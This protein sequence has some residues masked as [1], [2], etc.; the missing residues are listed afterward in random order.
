MNYTGYLMVGVVVVVLALAPMMCSDAQRAEANFYVATDGNDAWSGSLPAPNAAGTDGPFATLTQ[1]RD[2]IREL[3]ATVGLHQPIKVLVRGGTYYLPETLTLGPEDSGTA[4]FPITYMAY[5]DE[6]VV[7]GGGRVITGWKPYRGQIWQ[8]DLNALGLGELSF[9]QLFYNG[10][11]QPLARVPNVDPQH[12][13]T[14]GWLYV[15]ELVMERSK[16][17]LK[18]D[19]NRLD[20][21]KWAHPLLAEVDI[22]PGVTLANNIAAIGEIDLTNHIITLAGGGAGY[23][24]LIGNRFYI[25][26]V[27]EELDAAGEWYLDRESGI[28]Y[29]WPPDDNLAPGEVVVP[30]LGSIIQI[31]GDAAN[32]AYVRYLRLGGFALQVCQ[33]DAVSLHAA[34]H[35]TIAKCTITNTGEGGVGV[36]SFCSDNRVVGN[37]IAYTGASGV[38][39]T[40]RDARA[41]TVPESLNLPWKGF[42]DRKEYV[43]TTRNLVSNNH[44]HHFGVIWRG[45]EGGLSLH[46]RANVAS[47]NLI[48]DGPR[49][50]I[51]FGTGDDYLIEYND[52]HHVNLETADS[53]GIY[54]W[55]IHTQKGNIIRFN[56]VYDSIGYGMLSP[57]KWASPAFTWGIYLDA[58]ASGFT[59]Y[60]N[61]IVRN[62]LGGIMVQSGKQ[63]IIA[64][65]ILVEGSNLQI[66]YGGF[67]VAGMANNRFARNIVSYTNP[68]AGLVHFAKWLPPFWPEENIKQAVAESDY[69]L[70]FHPGHD[71]IVGMPQSVVAHCIVDWHQNVRLGDTSDIPPAESFAKWQELGYEAHSII[72]DPL[73]VDPA[74]D[75]YR[76]R[77]ESPAFKLGFKPIPV[78][79]IGLYP[80]PNRASWPVDDQRDIW[81]EEPVLT[82][83]TKPQRPR[84]EFKARK[85]TAGIIVDGEVGEWPWNEAPRVMVLQQ[86]PSGLPTGAPKSYG[87]AAYD[88]EA[89]Y[90]AIRNLVGDP[91]ALKTEGKWG[92]K[93]GVEIAF[94]D[95]SGDEPG[96][97]LNLYG[98]PDGQ[99]ESVTT[100]GAP[101]EV[102]RRLGQAVTYAAQVGS[103]DWTCEWRIPWAATGIDPSQAKKLWFNIGVYKTAADAWVNWEGT[104]GAI[105]MVE[106]AGDLI[107]RP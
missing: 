82:A 102:A 19:P 92:E 32:D 26:N 78:E 9:K 96:P 101:Q 30:T 74:N 70:F 51:T 18:Y 53:G 7:L 10:E 63:D 69:N 88:D 5:P 46:G 85:D 66:W 38:V 39:V 52:M 29:F 50:A 94:Q 97:I 45:F 16:R 61:I 72:A 35:C 22:W 12:P 93:D 75:D 42:G 67:D 41:K 11:R 33:G 47:H 91:T 83:P 4:S 84:P 77:P 43:L 25:Q 79:R 105:Y 34:Q 103:E 3:K 27:F 89:L 2:A 20:P 90:I 76:L 24:I 99:F 57:G 15:P 17:L 71:L 31:K 56:K 100:A 95:V 1:A 54:G 37:D 44:I 62:V 68:D 58:F 21:S 73:F 107:L 40:G 6:K 28:L 23:N 64:N 48:H 80:S 36:Y 13:R 8:Y 49:C 86:S 65:N 104:G 87:C 55:G 14:G 59:V 60:G 81:R 106:D 98:Y